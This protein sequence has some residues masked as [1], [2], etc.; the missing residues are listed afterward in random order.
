MLFRSLVD[1]SEGRTAARPEAV[2]LLVPFP[3]SV[4]IVR[5]LPIGASLGYSLLKPA[6]NWSKD[7]ITR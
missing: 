5:G 3:F 2:D 7:N 4:K 1:L 6:W